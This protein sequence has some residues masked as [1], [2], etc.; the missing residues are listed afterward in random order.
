MRLGRVLG[1]VWATVKDPRLEGIKLAIMQ[2]IDE[3]QKPMG[4]PVI[5]A[6]V[7]SARENDLVFWVGSAEACTPFADKMIPSDATIVGFVD[8]IDI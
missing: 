2:P 8:R 7:I 5:A 4:S 6:N 3:H 1:K